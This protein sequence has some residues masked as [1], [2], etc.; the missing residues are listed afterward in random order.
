MN[1]N[2]VGRPP[3]YNINIRKQVIA[4]RDKGFHR[5]EIADKFGISY[6][7]VVNILYAKIKQKASKKYY[8][9]NRKK[10]VKKQV[11]YMRTYKKRK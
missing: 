9:K 6:Y 2:K 1:K 11:E 8:L 7:T 10:I 3:Q 4:M 5:Q